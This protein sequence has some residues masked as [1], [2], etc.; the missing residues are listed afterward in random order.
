M[1]QSSIKTWLDK[2]SNTQSPES[3][4]STASRLTESTDIE[5]S[6]DSPKDITSATSSNVNSVSIN[7]FSKQLVLPPNVEICSVTKENL[8]QFRRLIGLVLP[9]SYGDAFY[10][11]VLSDA[12][13]SKLTLVAYWREDSNSDPRMVAG[14]S[15]KI[16]TE[17]HDTRI[18]TYDMTTP[19]LYITTLGTLSPYRGHGIAEELVQR[20]HRIAVNEFETTCMTAHVWESNDD[21]RLWYKNR[22][23]EEVGF[24]K[25]YY[26]RLKPS[27]AW[28]LERLTQP[29]DLLGRSLRISGETASLRLRPPTPL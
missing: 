22:G 16:I 10:S 20:I 17:S 29:S 14:I 15:G 11:S 21:A 8:T 26:R 25:Q 13:T 12:T 18:G 24:D 27:S 5:D 2:N 28:L 23:F 9:V 1:R 19:T 6:R 3:V 4:P 7:P